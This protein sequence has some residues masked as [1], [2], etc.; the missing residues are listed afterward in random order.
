MHRHLSRPAARRPAP[1]KSQGGAPQRRE[2]CSS[3]DAL[4]GPVTDWSSRRPRCASSCWSSERGTRRMALFIDLGC[5]SVALPSLRLSEGRRFRGSSSAVKIRPS[6]NPIGCLRGPPATGARPSRSTPREDFPAGRGP[7]MPTPGS[8]VL[9]RRV[10]WSSA[11]PVDFS[12]GF[13]AGRARKHERLP[14]SRVSM[15]EGTFVP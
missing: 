2:P 3:F 5:V 6:S 15:A 10:Y 13:P 12:G 1:V 7:D 11:E 4:L 8:G 14:I 9:R